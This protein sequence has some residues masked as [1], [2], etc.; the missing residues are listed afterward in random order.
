MQ[1]WIKKTVAISLPKLSE[2]S[3]YFLI[4]KIVALWR[5]RAMVV[6]AR[7]DRVYSVSSLQRLHKISALKQ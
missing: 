2:K 1:R 7:F 5:C 4:E 6:F 3:L